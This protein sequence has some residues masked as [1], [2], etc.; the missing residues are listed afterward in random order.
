MR[1]VVQQPVTEDEFAE[2]I[3]DSQQ[4]PRVP[5]TSVGKATVLGFD[6]VRLREYLQEEPEAPVIA[7][8]RQGEPSSEQ[9]LAH[10]R[11]EAIAHAVRDVDTDPLSLEELWQLLV[12]PGRGLRTPYTVVGDELV[13]GY[14]IPKLERVLGLTPSEAR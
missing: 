6:P 5:F 10:L 2:L 4:R 1:D 7:H 14:D 12:I 11:T 8:V 9:L 13:L 3:L